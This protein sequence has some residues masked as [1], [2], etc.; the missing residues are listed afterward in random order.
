MQ[1]GNGSDDEDDESNMSEGVLD[2]KT[3]AGKVSDSEGDKKEPGVVS[4]HDSPNFENELKWRSLQ[5][6]IDLLPSIK[7]ATDDDAQDDSLDE[8][9]AWTP[10]WAH[11][12]FGSRSTSGSASLELMFDFMGVES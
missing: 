6:Q 7:Q 10:D 9:A 1:V 8:G 5:R 2:E 4:R 12:R 3:Q 11:W